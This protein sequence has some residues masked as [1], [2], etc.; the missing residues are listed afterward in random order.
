MRSREDYTRIVL[1][2]LVLSIGILA[3][4]QLYLLREPARIANVLAADQSAQIASG[5]K[6]FADNCATCHGKLGEGDMGPALNDKKFLKSTDDGVIFSLVGS[7]VPGTGM[8]S[9]SQTHGGPFTDEQI[10]DVVSFVRHWEATAPDLVKASPTPDPAKGEAIFKATCYACHGV[11]GEGTDRAPALNSQALLAQFDDAWFHQ[12]IADGRPSKG[13]PTWG[14]VLSPAQ[15][16]SVVA[17]IRSWQTGAPVAVAATPTTAPSTPI[18]Q[19]QATAEVSP[20]EEIARPS[21]GNLTPG[22]AVNLVGDSASGAK[23]FVENCQKCHGEQGKGGVDNAGSTD[24]TVPPLNPIDDTLVSQDLK[25]F[26][27][28]IDLFIEHGSV[29]EGDNPKLVM[30]AWG[31]RAKLTPQQIADVITYVMGLNGATVS[32][33][34][35]EPTVVATETPAADI[36]RPSN[37]NLTPGPAITQNLQGNNVSGETIFVT[38]CQKCHGEQG[39][40][41]VANAGST[42]GTVPPLKPID[43]TLVS[44]DLELFATNIDLF[45]E[46]GSVPEGD[47]PKLVMDAWGDKSKLTPQQIADVITYVMGLNGATTTSATPMP[48]AAATETPAPDIARPSNGNLTPGAAVNLVGNS[49]SGETIFV[50]N[51]QKCHGEQGKGGIDNAG[52]TDG[53]VPPLNPIDDTLVSQDLKVFATNIDL[54]IEH[55]S[56]PEGDNPK[57]VMDAWGDKAKL[58]PQQIADV[59][60]YLIELNHH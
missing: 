11:N 36:A 7:G 13:M 2:A 25:T 37:G 56:T 59:I 52:S 46:H 47:N 27:T 60:A 51:C 57:L 3:A 40:G 18:P 16:S 5:E 38:N 12:T 10:R 44:Q 43:D 50:T 48:N 45:I 19:V 14:L 34:T 21:N 1:V 55:G 4:F 58:T 30:D 32:S 31:D 9:W 20:T 17:Y 53:T 42:D 22:A 29:P 39:K 41:G 15:I 54:F 24:G 8:P 49:T 28:N 26:A 6:L 23:I 35:P 33:A